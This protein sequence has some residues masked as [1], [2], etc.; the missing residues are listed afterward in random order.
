[1]KREIIIN[2]TFLKDDKCHK[3]HKIQN[4]PRPEQWG[5][6]AFVSP[7]SV[8]LTLIL[9]FFFFFVPHLHFFERLSSSPPF[10]HNVFLPNHRHPDPVHIAPLKV[11]SHMSP[12]VPHHEIRWLLLILCVPGIPLAVATH[13]WNQTP[14]KLSALS[15]WLISP[16]KI[17]L[18]FLSSLTSI[19]CSPLSS[20]QPE[21]DD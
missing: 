21:S 13:N 12:V 14:L 15:L 8:T 16:S 6:L 9:E 2:W 4:I 3:Y 5:S 10:P 1:M 20:N 17:L 19:L 18:S 7:G 11:S